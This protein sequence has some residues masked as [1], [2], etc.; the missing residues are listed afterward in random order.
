M[1]DEDEDAPLFSCRL[2][3]RSI[4]LH[5][6]TIA[7]HVIYHIGWD[8][9]ISKDALHCQLKSE[10]ANHWKALTKPAVNTLLAKIPKLKIP[11][12]KMAK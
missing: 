11:G 3:G 5:T 10:A 12:G 1:S 8:A 2:N 4:E 7:E 9:F 6:H